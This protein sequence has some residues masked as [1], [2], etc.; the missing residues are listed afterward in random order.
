MIESVLLTEYARIDTTE[1][2]SLPILV[3][4]SNLGQQPDGATNAMGPISLESKD[5]LKDLTGE[6][7][8]WRTKGVKVK[9]G[10]KV[11][12][13]DVKPAILVSCV[14]DSSE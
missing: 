10:S 9:K 5:W 3:T 12:S 8:S 4:D 13:I 2:R 14:D 1:M 6:G 11:D 7:R